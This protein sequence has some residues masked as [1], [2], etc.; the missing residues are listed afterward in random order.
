MVRGL[1]IAQKRALQISGRSLTRNTIPD[2]GGTHQWNHDEGSGTT[3][4]D[5][6]ASL[7]GSINGATWESGAGADD[8]YLKYDG[9]TD[10]TDLGLD[11]RSEFRH[12]VEDGIGSIFLWIRPATT[13]E[14][15][16]VIGSGLKSENVN[17]A[18]ELND[19][20]NGDIRWVIHNSESTVWD[21][22]GVTA[23]ITAGEWQPIAATVDG[24]GAACVY[25]G[26]PSEEYVVSKVASDS[27]D[28]DDL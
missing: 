20:A 10:N 17:I 16:T 25:R 9:S 14:R 11:S 18:I 27:F 19:D 7:D 24:V 4:T 26:N 21:T 5:S 28:T 12:F 6:I 2:S 23:S 15:F 22:G 8:V 1:T 13:S 3:L